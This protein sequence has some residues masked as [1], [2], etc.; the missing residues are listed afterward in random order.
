MYCAISRLSSSARNVPF[1]WNTLSPLLLVANAYS[2]I[3]TQLKDTASWKTSLSAP[4]PPHPQ[5][6]AGTLGLS[7]YSTE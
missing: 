5:P 7:F 6:P 2:L 4:P 1:A 3:K